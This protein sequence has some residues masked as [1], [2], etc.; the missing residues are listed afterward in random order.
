MGEMDSNKPQC[1]VVHLGRESPCFNHE[2]NHVLNAFSVPW[3]LG[4]LCFLPKKGKIWLPDLG[5][6]GDVCQGHALLVSCRCKMLTDSNTQENVPVLGG[7]N[8]FVFKG[9]R[10]VGLDFLFAV[11]RTRRRSQRLAEGP[12]CLS[13]A[14]GSSPQGNSRSRGLQ[15]RGS[16]GC[17]R[18]SVRRGTRT[19]SPAE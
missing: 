2:I 11:S 17:W 8:G 1:L 4:C 3:F 10:G 6:N 16:T 18:V 14:R 19:S 15:Q 12:Q 5:L 7:V 9:R 13:T